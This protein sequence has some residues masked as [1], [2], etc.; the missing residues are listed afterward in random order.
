MGAQSKTSTAAPWVA[1]ALTGTVISASLLSGCYGKQLFRQP[2]TVDEMSESVQSLREQQ[3]ELAKN[4]RAL[5][6][7]LAK[8][9]DLVRQ[10]K[11]ENDSRASDLEAQ[12]LSIDS[13][14]QDLLTR[15]G[16]S[17]SSGSTFTPPRPMMADT[18]RFSGGTVPGDSA[19]GPTSPNTGD[20]P[21]AEAK[22][23][24]DQAY[25]DN[26]KSNFQLS[27]TGFR[28]YLRR[29]P[30]GDLSDNAQ[31]WIGEAY[32]AQRDFETA[33]Q[34]FNK[35][36]DT[37]P[38]GDKVPAALLKIAYSYTQLGD[39]NA[40]V[41]YLNRVIDEYPN[42]DEAAPAKNKLRQLQ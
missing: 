2:I 30:N 12:L 33:I 11:A 37:F 41:R 8:Q 4:L 19:S 3:I 31:Y 13:K 14:L 26:T 9:A 18:T 7:Q 1:V 29:V 6:D 38:K 32:Y 24:Y 22:R 28:E 16:G 35:V 27:I 25:F 34:E 23:I 17:S 10:L 40:A 21:E 20:T 15:R 5:E 39:K 42:S 36:L